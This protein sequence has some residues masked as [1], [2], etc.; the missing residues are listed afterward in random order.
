[1]GLKAYKEEMERMHRLVRGQVEASSTAQ[2]WSVDAQRLGAYQSFVRN[3]VLDMLA[4]HYSCL[5][6][7]LESQQWEALCLDYYAQVPCRDYDLNFAAAG[8]SAFLAQEDVL[9]KYALNALHMELCLLEWEEFLAFK[10]K[11]RW[12]EVEPG[13]L[14]LLNPALSIFDFSFPT[15][16]FLLA[17]RRWHSEKKGERPQIPE[18]ASERV[19]VLQH[20]ASLLSRLYVATPELLLTFKGAHDGLTRKQMCDASGLSAARIAELFADAANKGIL[21]LCEE[22]KG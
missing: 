21:K 7:V 16:T 5:A 20:P 10:K 4:K 17:W 6:D 3:H 11:V 22:D 12:P 13:R 19:F 2:E 14:A 9:E 15:G 8:F 1:M 18:P